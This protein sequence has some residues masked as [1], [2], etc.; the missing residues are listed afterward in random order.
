M[1]KNP[2]RD[3][4]PTFRARRSGVTVPAPAVIGDIGEPL[5]MAGGLCAPLSPIYDLPHF[6]LPELTPEEKFELR[7]EMG[8]SEDPNTPEGWHFAE[9]FGE[10]CP[11]Y[12]G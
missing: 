12:W 1:R 10:Q 8:R 5:I 7:L 9:R 4:L 2:L 11:D 6:D 3:A